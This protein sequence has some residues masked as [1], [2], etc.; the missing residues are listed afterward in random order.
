M[1]LRTGNLWDA[2]ADVGATVIAVTT[3][4]TVTRDGRLVMGRGAALEAKR[5]YPGIDYE[6]GGHINLF[7]NYHHHRR[8][9]WMLIRAFD[10]PRFGIFQVKHYWRDAADLDL[11][12]NSC[13]RLREWLSTKAWPGT[14]VALN[15]P[16]IGNGRLAREAVLPII[17]GLPDQVAIY[18]R[19]E[20]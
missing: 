11:I 20:L 12:R 14:V 17:S 16:G 9:G 1:I 15:F 8:Y 4:S 19:G 18:E 2:P 7:A 3:N 6:A 5:R 10:Q 13:E